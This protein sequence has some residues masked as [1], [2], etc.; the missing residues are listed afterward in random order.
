MLGKSMVILYADETLNTMFDA[1]HSSLVHQNKSMTDVDIM[2]Y[3]EFLV[4]Q[5]LVFQ[6]MEDLNQYE[7]DFFEELSESYRL[8]TY[9]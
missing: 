1:L 4:R 9:N 3:V 7:D 8:M 5:G 6:S 2:N